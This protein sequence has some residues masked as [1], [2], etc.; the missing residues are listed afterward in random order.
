MQVEMQLHLMYCDRPLI[1]YNV[2]DGAARQINTKDYNATGFGRVAAG[3]LA[4]EM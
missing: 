1:E 2:S 3:N 4:L